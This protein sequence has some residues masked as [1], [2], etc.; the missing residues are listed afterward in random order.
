MSKKSF[1]VL[2]RLLDVGSDKPLPFIGFMAETNPSLG[3]RG[4]RFLREYPELLKT[5]L[6]AVLALASEFDVRVPSN[7]LHRLA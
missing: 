2:M 5:Q 1:R 3:R 6:R 7:I 4:I